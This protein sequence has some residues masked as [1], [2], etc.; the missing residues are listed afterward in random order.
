MPTE[1][2]KERS[3]A[4]DYAVYLAVRCVICVI[5]TLPYSLAG[6]LAGAL[7][8][9]A[10]RI[11]KRHRQVAFDNLGSAFPGKYSPDERKEKVR[12][13]YRHFCTVLIEII[14]LPRLLHPTTWRRHL[15][16]DKSKPFVNLLLSGRP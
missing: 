2:S 5:Q 6:Q 13:V 10:E 8:W 9:L 16:L 3:R 15:S 7:A 12:G 14:H 4:K 11:D 1:R